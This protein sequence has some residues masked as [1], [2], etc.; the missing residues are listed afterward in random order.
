MSG[1]V[2]CSPILFA[3]EIEAQAK[4]AADMD[5]MVTLHETYL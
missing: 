5:M 3:D 4:V 2:S 1:L